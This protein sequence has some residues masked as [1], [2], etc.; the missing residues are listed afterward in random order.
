M[1]DPGAKAL[2]ARAFQRRRAQIEGGACLVQPNMIASFFKPK[3]QKERLISG[4]AD[5]KITGVDNDGGDPPDHYRCCEYGRPGFTGFAQAPAL[6]FVLTPKIHLAATKLS[7][8][9]AT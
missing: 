7:H 3:Q 2:I 5:V 4:E 6:I 8:H 9:A 1:V